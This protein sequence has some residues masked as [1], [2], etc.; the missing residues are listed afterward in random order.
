ME[1]WKETPGMIGEVPEK[2]ITGVTAEIP[3]ITYYGAKNKT[4]DIAIVIFPG[5]GYGGRADHEGRG[6]AEFFNENGIDA[7]VC[8]Y[9]VYPHHFPI[10]LLDARRA[11]RW[12]RY[13]ADEYG[14]NK[15]KILVIGSSAGGSL[16]TLVSTYKKPIEFEGID[17]I[18][19]E[20]PFPNGQ[21]LCYP[22]VTLENDDITHMGSKRCLLGEEK[23]FMAKD[24]S[25]ENNVSEDTPKA[26][27]WHTAED[28]CVN[29]INSYMYATALRA[30]NVPVEMHIFPYGGHGMGTATFMPYVGRWTE[31]LLE[32][33][34]L[35]FGA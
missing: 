20:S 27:I 6:Y 25:P 17:E 30:K 35:E 22:V 18:D 29:V 12:V 23:L 2:V 3:Q 13:H 7:F 5:G 28:D 26:F 16:A 4:S 15:D 21:I 14:I 11:V 31:L 32:W 33:L 8:D 24:I 34:K 9:R 10:P 19:N 1:M